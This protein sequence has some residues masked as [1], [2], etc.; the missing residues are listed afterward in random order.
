LLVALPGTGIE[1]FLAKAPDVI[2]YVEHGVCDIGIVGKDTIAEQGGTYYE[3]MNLGI[4]RCKFALAAPK[5]AD[6]FGGYGAKTVATKYPNVAERYFAG[7]GMDVEI[8]KIEGS[9]EIAPLLSLADAIIDIV[10]TGV[11]LEENGLEVIEDIR[12]VSARFI[13][14]VTSMKLRKEE[15]DG[16]AA[17]LSAAKG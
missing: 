5:G 15:I 13:V 11:T 3:I 8:I 4:G 2:T 10:E 1:F 17:R 6:F 9:V 12:D 7:K 16:F 14:N